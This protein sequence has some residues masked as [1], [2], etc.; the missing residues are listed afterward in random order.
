L[1]PA[2]CA[3]LVLGLGR[4][5][6]MRKAVEGEVVNLVDEAVL[7]GVGDKSPNSQ[8]VLAGMGDK[9]PNSQKASGIPDN[10]K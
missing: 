8:T 5:L 4:W 3:L 6:A 1:I 9:S 2:L 7:S 10:I